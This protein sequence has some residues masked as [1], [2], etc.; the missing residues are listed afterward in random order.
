MN[1]KGSTNFER[2]RLEIQKKISKMTLN[3]LFFVGCILCTE[4][5]K[6][7]INVVVSTIRSDTHSLKF[8]I[9]WSSLYRLF[10][11]EIIRF[12][13]NFLLKLKL[14]SE[15]HILPSQNEMIAF[16]KVLV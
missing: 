5:V 13:R 10:Q 7:G 11:K 6:Y 8:H 9:A 16:R 4:T 15:I 14:G 3:S 1:Y 2:W 12:R